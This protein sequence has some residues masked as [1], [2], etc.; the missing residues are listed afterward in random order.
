[1]QMSRSCRGISF[2]TQA[3]YATVFL[4]RYPDLFFRFISLYNSLMKIVLV[5]T[6]CYILY[7]MRYKYRLTHD[8]AID[9]FKVEYL[10][11][12][13]FILSL[14]FNYRYTILEIL[15]SFSIFLESV[16]IFPQLS[17]LQRTGEAGMVTTHYVVALG[18]YRAFQNLSWIH[19]YEAHG[20]FEPIRIVTGVV[21]T[22]LYLIFFYIYFTRVDSSQCDEKQNEE[23]QNEEKQN[24]EKQNEE[25]QSEEKISEKSAP[26]QEQV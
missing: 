24:E 9:T 12:P 21:Q 6:S 23:K 18:A 26:S 25:K 2:K 3:L 17:M 16:A 15:W 19:R 22:V 13:C 11:A 7:L 10:V 20:I 1:M 5:G 14:I 4:A 8:P